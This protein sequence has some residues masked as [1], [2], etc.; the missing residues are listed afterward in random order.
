VSEPLL[1]PELPL[2]PLVVPLLDPLDVDTPDSSPPPSDSAARVVPLLLH[3]P[4]QVT[5]ATAAINPILRAA[6][7]LFLSGMEP[8]Q[9]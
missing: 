6:L 4:A 2:D 1:A 7:R 8:S 3:P 9:S 5:H